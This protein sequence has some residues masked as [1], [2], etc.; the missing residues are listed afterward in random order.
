MATAKDS[1]QLLHDVAHTRASRDRLLPR[2]VRDNL[3]TIA[4]DTSDVDHPKPGSPQAFFP[5]PAI[6]ARPQLDSEQMPGMNLLLNFFHEIPASLQRI[7]S[8]CA[9]GL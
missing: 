5:S 9:S 1:A 8:S 6:L 4:L 7:E 2:C 3:W